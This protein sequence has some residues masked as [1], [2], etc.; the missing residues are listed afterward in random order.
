MHGNQD[1]N[2]GQRGQSEICHFL[3][4]LQKLEKTTS[5]SHTYCVTFHQWVHTRGRLPQRD[6]QKCRVLWLTPNRPYGGVKHPPNAWYHLCLC[7]ALDLNTEMKEK[8]LTRP[9]I[10]TLHFFSQRYFQRTKLNCDVSPLNSIWDVRGKKKKNL[11]RPLKDTSL[12]WRHSTSDYQ[13]QS[14]EG[15]QTEGAH[16]SPKARECS[17]ASPYPI[18]M[19]FPASPQPAQGAPLRHGKCQERQEDIWYLWYH[20][21]GSCQRTSTRQKDFAEERQ[22]YKRLAEGPL[23]NWISIVLSS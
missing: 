8:I 10:T 5:T 2:V 19:T 23:S 18:S 20:T 12:C 7:L 15:C 3:A 21:L 11:S 13:T 22:N 14:R 9:H 4:V 1:E 6:R 17:S 16:L